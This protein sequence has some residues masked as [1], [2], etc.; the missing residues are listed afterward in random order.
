MN[1][2]PKIADLANDATYGGNTDNAY[3]QKYGK[4]EYV[5]QP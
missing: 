1:W 2:G 3:T 4:H 5:L